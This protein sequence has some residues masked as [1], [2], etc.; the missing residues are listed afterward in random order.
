MKQIFS[1]CKPYSSIISMAVSPVEYLSL[2][3]VKTFST[4]YN[5]GMKLRLQMIK[6]VMH[7]CI[8]LH[9]CTYTCM[10]TLICVCVMCICVSMYMYVLYKLGPYSFCVFPQLSTRYIKAVRLLVS[11]SVSKHFTS[12]P[13]GT[14]GNEVNGV[15]LDA[16][17]HLSAM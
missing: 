17:I 12:G 7:T 13:S 3:R 16:R 5:T 10:Y 4:Y 9:V 15:G 6:T 8:Y 11:K 1:L 14:R 2:W